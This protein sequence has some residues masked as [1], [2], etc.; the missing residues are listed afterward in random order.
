MKYIKVI[1]YLLS[2][3]IIL[4]TMLIATS[5]ISSAADLNQVYNALNE[6]RRAQSAL[7]QAENTLTSFLYNQNRVRT[8]RIKTSL[9]TFDADGADDAIA[10]S[11][12]RTKCRQL[13][14]IPSSCD[15]AVLDICWDKQQ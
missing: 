4:A 7:Y 9:N 14:F 8:C 5:L 1:N 12:A 11:N 15:S 10:I 6:V 2:S 3:K 13:G